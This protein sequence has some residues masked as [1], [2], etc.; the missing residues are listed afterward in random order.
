M[1]IIMKE[2]ATQDQIQQFTEYIEN[3]GFGAHISVGDVHTVIGAVGPYSMD[4]RDIELL[5]GV[6]EVIKITSNY[7]LASRVFQKEDTII[8]VNSVKFGG[9]NVGIIAGPITV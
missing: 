7:K 3:K 1:L 6:K 8:N 5:D 2:D 4:K 9:G